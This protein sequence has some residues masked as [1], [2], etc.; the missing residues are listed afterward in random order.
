MS[1]VTVYTELRTRYNTMTTVPPTE[2][3]NE[4]FVKPKTLWSRFNIIDGEEMQL[5]I[6]YVTKTFR[7]QG[8][9]IIQ[10]FAPLNFGSIDALTQADLIADHFRNWYGTTITCREAS[11][12]NIGSDSF[13]WYQVNVSIPFHADFIK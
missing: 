5:D 6:G 2:F 8:V 1:A 7:H 10:V 11:I 3:P 12:D 13:G 9:L 4:A